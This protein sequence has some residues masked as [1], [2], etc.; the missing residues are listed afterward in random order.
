MGRGPWHA[1]ERTDVT[2]ATPGNELVGVKNQHDG[3]ARSSGTQPHVSLHLIPP[4]KDTDTVLNLLFARRLALV[5]VVVIEPALVNKYAAFPLER[6]FSKLQ[7][8]R[9]RAARAPI[10]QLM[11]TLDG[12]LFRH[13]AAFVITASMPGGGCSLKVVNWLTLPSIVSSVSSRH[14]IAVPS[15]CPLL[16]L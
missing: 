3:V 11:C 12:I 15:F 2:A 10:L 9:I 14:S 16:A 5:R 8:P 13:K 4:H 6:A 7:E 1:G